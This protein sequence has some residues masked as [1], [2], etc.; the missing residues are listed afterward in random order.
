M[1]ARRLLPVHAAGV[2][3]LVLL[4]CAANAPVVSPK[5]ATPAA[6]VVPPCP[7]SIAPGGD[8]SSADAFEGKR[9]ARV[10]VVGGGETSRTAAERV[11]L[12]HTGDAYS[13]SRVRADLEGLMKLG[14][15]DDVAVYGLPA[16]Q[17][18]NV[19]V[20]YAI[21]DRPRIA[22][23]A[24]EGV[25]VMADSEAVKQLLLAKGTPYQPMRINA[26]AQSVRDEYIARGYAACRV[27]LVTEP[28]DGFPVQV[29]VRIK[30]DEGPLWRLSQLTF[31]GNKKI[32]EADLRKAAGL[33]VGQPFV[34]EEI[35]RA[36]L[37][38]SEMI[39]D[40]GLIAMHLDPEQG[41]VDDKGDVPLAFA[42]EEGDVHT[43]SALHIT[44]LGAASE[45]EI[46][47][48]VMRARPKQ[49]FSH[50]ALMKD[51]AR[52]KELFKNRG[53]PVGIDLVTRIDS[54]KHT[55]DVTLEVYALAANLAD[56]AVERCA[57]DLLAELGVGAAFGA[58]ATLDDGEHRPGLGVANESVHRAAEG[59]RLGA[60]DRDRRA[61]H[62]WGTSCASRSG[63]LRRRARR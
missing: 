29:H 46:L 38:L 31:R 7:D 5:P 2:L 20:L 17:G 57:Q 16:R 35:E 49:V 40:R 23:I 47:G 51:I 4:G 21:R 36:T 14:T 11:L 13:A 15:L 8:A 27:V 6:E 3:T 55:V 62:W 52:V 56:R 34:K 45:L 25:K 32:T 42:V 60:D 22:D 44:G 50:T 24:F 10:C 59:H 43:I 30:V 19:T 58:G 39:S 9:V 54:K 28:A 37:K 26:V 12:L 63:S 18:A 48:K 53:Q 41:A 1:R 33:T 61:A